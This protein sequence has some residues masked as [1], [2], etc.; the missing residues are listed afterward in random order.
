MGVG[1]G[2]VALLMQRV[3]WLNQQLASQKL[4]SDSVLTIAHAANLLS[5]AWDNFVKRMD[6]ELEVNQ[7]QVFL[8]ADWLTLFDHFKKFIV[9]AGALVT[10]W[11]LVE[12]F[13]Q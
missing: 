12:S 11:T 2:L 5:G 8:I 13:I 10:A 9:G 7:I 3:I 6:K 4:E 1:F